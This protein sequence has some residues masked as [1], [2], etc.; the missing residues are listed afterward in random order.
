MEQDKTMTAREE[1]G[2]AQDLKAAAIGDER[3]R[4][5]AAHKFVQPARRLDQIGPRLQDQVVGVTKH[6][7]LTGL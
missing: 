4:G 6:E 2:R 1:R 3:A 5:V 7:L